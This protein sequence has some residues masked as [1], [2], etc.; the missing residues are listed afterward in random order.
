[1]SASFATSAGSHRVPQWPGDSHLDPPPVPLPLR[2]AALSFFIRTVVLERLLLSGVLASK[3]D[4]VLPS[5]LK[6]SMADLPISEIA[7]KGGAAR[8]KQLSRARRSEI[9]QR[10]AEARW[11]R[12]DRADPR[13][14]HEGVLPIG[15]IELPVAVLEGG[16]RVVTGGAMLSALGRP[17]KGSYKRTGLPS[18][19]DAP[20]LIPLMTQELLDVLEPIQYISLA[21]RKR[22]LGYRAELVPLVCDVYL[23]A[24]EQGE[25]HPS[26]RK[27]AR[28]AEILVRSLSKV[29]IVALVDEATGYQDDRAR[30]ELQK[31][32]AAYIA[33][34]LLPWTRRFPDEFFK[35]IYR[36]HGWEFK[37]GSLK[38][39]RYVGKLVNKLV[40][41]PLPP[42]VL[43]EL[44][45]LNPPN[46]KGQRRYRHH[47]FLTE[48]I[49]NP[50]LERQIIEVTTLMRVADDKKTFEGL[51]RKA[52][53]MSGQQM[54][55]A[56]L[57]AEN[58]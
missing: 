3:H 57:S 51:F 25:L 10:A 20:N 7:A 54:Q 43:D 12:T 13:A 5:C 48:D 2:F 39:P 22:V 6:A 8:A 33:S 1:L 21:T 38:G 46:D 36:L 58:G 23:S 28:Q 41:E 37:P 14:T 31:I 53:P 18:F 32:L 49:G 19:L 11:D 52:F 15:K 4:L 24:R 40:Y 27:T 44:K 50:H 56:L 16:I 34:E 35:Q 42:G 9:A 45:R 30:D 29:G 26:Q 17:W 47:Q 55:L